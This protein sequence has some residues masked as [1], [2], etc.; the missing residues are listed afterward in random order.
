MCSSDGNIQNDFLIKD[1]SGSNPKNCL[2][3]IVLIIIVDVGIILKITLFP[4][5][6]VRN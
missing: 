1:V 5:E 2:N 3:T 4:E 6:V